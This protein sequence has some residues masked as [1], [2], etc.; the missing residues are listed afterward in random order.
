[1]VPRISPLSLGGPAAP[2][3]AFIPDGRVLLFPVRRE[4]LR[5]RRAPADSSE[6]MTDA[7]DFAPRWWPGSAFDVG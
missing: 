6:D 4:D 7:A 3:A 5:P 2:A 1:M